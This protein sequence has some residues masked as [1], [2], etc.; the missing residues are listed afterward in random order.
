M[1]IE[2]DLTRAEPAWQQIAD[3]VLGRL[4]AGVVGVG[5]RLPSVRGLAQEVRVNPNTVA[6]AYRELESL[7]AVEGRQGRGVFV[8]PGGPELARHRRGRALAVGIRDVVARALG[9]GL[10]DEEIRAAVESALAREG[11]RTKA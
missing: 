1:Q 11:R 7:G 5:E 2:I 10:T 6:R 3:G 9:A 4:A 8:T